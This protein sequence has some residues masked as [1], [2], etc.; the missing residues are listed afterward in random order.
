MPARRILCIAFAALTPLLIFARH[1]M[2]DADDTI[3]LTLGST[4]QHDSNL[5]RLSS[6]ADPNAV[7]GKSSKSDQ[8]S[9]STV[10]LKI[11]K[12][13][14]LQPF[15]LE[16]SIVDSRYHTFNYLNFTARNYAAAWRW[17]L[18]P[19][20]YGNLTATRKES[21]NSFTDYTGY[22]TRNLNT[23]ENRRFDGVF[24]IDGVWRILG[25]V[26]QSDNTNS[27]LFNQVGDSRVNTA[28]AGIRY[29]FPSGSSITYSSKTGRGE[30]INRPQPILAGLYDNRF[31]DR[32]NELRLIWALTGKT[33]LDTRAA[34]LERKHANYSAR[35]YGGNVGN[36]NLNWE[37]T[38]KTRLTAGWARELSSYQASSSS[39]T[40]T[41]RLT[42]SPYWQFSAKTGLRLRYDY[43]QRDY[44][45][46][47]ANTAQNDR[48]DTQRVGMIALEWQP[49]R[50][51]SVSTS[52][53]SDK[54]ASNIPGLDYDAKIASISAQITF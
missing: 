39:Y 34:H 44:R 28:D 29:A 50:T 36:V 15:E 27:S 48:V 25:G 3:N 13:Y 1:A 52:L 51:L 11:N 19:Y 14:S 33:S 23:A 35:D 46:A 40:S 2:A 30:Y 37:I 10:A 5:F 41:D 45:G 26:A 42:V 31:D 53:Q 18:T 12:P 20:A 43:A 38:G 16:S 21:L 47:I 6:S 4:V 24:E 9:I 17:K 49:L 22:N 8:I 32:E 54:R 7:L